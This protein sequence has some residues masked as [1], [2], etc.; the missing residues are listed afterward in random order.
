M[1]TSPFSNWDDAAE[2]FPWGPDSFGVWL[3]V[4]I[5]VVLFVAIIVRSVQ[6]ENESMQPVVQAAEKAESDGKVLEP[7]S[8]VV[9]A[10]GADA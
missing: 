10:A 6:H 4:V 8:V 9:A 3:F 5:G 7:K 2:L 1:N